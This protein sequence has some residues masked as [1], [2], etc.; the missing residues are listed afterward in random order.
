MSVSTVF[1][2]DASLV[3]QLMSM[4]TKFDDLQRQLSTQK[5]ATTYGSLGGKRSVDLALKQRIGEVDT[6]Q[7]TIDF[8]NLR[9]NTL[10]TTIGRMEEIRGEARSAIDP[11]NFVQ[12]NDGSTNSQ[13]SAEVSLVEM[14]ALLNTDAGGRQLYSGTSVDTVPVADYKTIMD[15]DAT[16]DGLRQVMD[17]YLQADT[18]PLDNGRVTTAR[19]AG[20]VT[21]AEDGAHMYGFK[22]VESTATPSNLTNV[23]LTYN[24]GPPADQSFDFTGQPE[25]GE[26]VKIYLNMPDGSQ[27]MV[28]LHVAGEPGETNGFELGATPDDTAQNFLESL[29][30]ALGEVAGTELKAASHTRAGERFF[31]TYQGKQIQRV[32]GPPFDTATAERDGTPDTVAWYVGD[33]STD[34]PRAGS[35]A[36]IDQSFN[37][38]YGV[39]ANEDGIREVV[40]SMAVFLA[41]D[42]SSDTESGHEFYS[43]MAGRSRGKL[44]DTAGRSSGIQRIQME[45]ATTHLAV[46]RVDER[47]TVTQASLITTVEEIEGV[48][49]EAVA[50]QMLQLQTMMEASYRATSILYN[51]SLA[52]YM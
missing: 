46:Q 43:A 31:D 9:L 48:D 8:V 33:N 20:A 14:L 29:D 47:H 50:A 26:S 10:D 5:S 25:V 28:E 7:R 1:F 35:T 52:D 3:K 12:Q 40:Q 34:D 42:F 23:N 39:R 27:T 49:L 21:L 44:A 6:Y 16:R 13:T 19:A 22:I 37:I 32:D 17:E 11:N 24:A 30:L 2:K 38:S 15:G 18:G 41:A 51:M 36:T 45:L 4:R